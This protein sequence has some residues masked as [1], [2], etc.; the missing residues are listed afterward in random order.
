VGQDVRTVQRAEAGGRARIT[1]IRKLAQAL[2]CEPSDLQA[3]HA[4]SATRVRTSAPVAT[5]PQGDLTIF[6][7]ARLTRGAR[8]YR[9]SWLGSGGHDVVN[10]IHEWVAHEAARRPGVR[11]AKRGDYPVL[12]ITFQ[13]RAEFL[14]RESWWSAILFVSC[15]QQGRPQ[16]VDITPYRWLCIDVRAYHRVP[17]RLPYPIPLRVR[18]EDASMAASLGSFHQSSSWSKKDLRLTEY[19]H[20]HRCDLRADFSWSRFAW[21][22]NTGR[23]DRHAI[24]QVTLGHDPGTAACRGTIE[25]RRVRFSV[26]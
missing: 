4:S 8:G 9:S 2:N 11:L 15:D 7:P 14:P 23:V 10:P 21:R 5:A 12:H 17:R 25:I 6:P 1:T 26:E 3:A 19:F 16:P 24:L 20:E 22:S 18:L 13:H